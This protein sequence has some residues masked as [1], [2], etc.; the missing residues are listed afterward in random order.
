MLLV[1]FAA[2]DDF[3]A[4]WELPTEDFAVG[5][6]EVRAEAALEAMLTD[7]DNVAAA[8][9]AVVAGVACVVLVD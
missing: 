5:E 6:L 3:D 4:D 9:L 7:S 1:K 8:E 2:V